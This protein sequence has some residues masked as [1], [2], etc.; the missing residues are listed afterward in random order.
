MARKKSRPA[1]VSA[2]SR[3]PSSASTAITTAPNPAPSMPS[4]PVAPAKPKT[5][6]PV[7]PERSVVEIS[8]VRASRLLGSL[9]VAVIGLSLF[10]AFVMLGTLMEHWYNTKIA[11]ELVYKSWWFIG[12]LFLLAVNIFF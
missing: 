7:A 10:A 4:A 3:G 6:G 5:S 9:Q 12:L 8:A 11:Q 2:P 1:P